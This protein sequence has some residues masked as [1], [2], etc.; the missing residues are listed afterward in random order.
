MLTASFVCETG[1]VWP[2]LS[3]LCEL[4]FSS[5]RYFRPIVETDWTTALVSA[6]SGSTLFSSFSSAIAVTR[7]VL[8]FWCGVSPDTSPT[9]VPAMRTWLDGISPDAS[10]SSTLM[11]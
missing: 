8:G 2:A 5:S 9:R 11:L 10:G 3:V 4:P 6:G 7:P 1:I